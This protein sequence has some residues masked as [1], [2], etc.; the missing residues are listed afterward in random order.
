MKIIYVNSE[1]HGLK[2]ILVDDEDFDDLS[3]LK[4]HVYKN[5][6]NFYARK[7]KR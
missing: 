5:K 7:Q 2:E 1:K 3:K 6:R 4:W